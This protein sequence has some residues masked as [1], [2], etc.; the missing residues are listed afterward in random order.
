MFDAPGKRQ[1]SSF[2]VDIDTQSGWECG[3]VG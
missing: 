1:D 2:F 3:K